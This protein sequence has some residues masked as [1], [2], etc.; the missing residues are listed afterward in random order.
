MPF[1]FWSFMKITNLYNNCENMKAGVA[2]VLVDYLLA[3]FFFFVSRFISSHFTPTGEF[4]TFIMD[5]KLGDER[6]TRQ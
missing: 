5:Y 6:K 1:T 4:N 2:L 3:S